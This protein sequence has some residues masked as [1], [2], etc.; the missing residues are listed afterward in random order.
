MN[1]NANTASVLAAEFEG[2]IEA[3]QLIESSHQQLHAEVARLRQELEDRNRALE[4]S[5]GQLESTRQLLMRILETLPC[6]VI[7]LNPTG[8]SVALANEEAR[9][10]LGLSALSGE[11][12]PE[13]LA[14]ILS[15]IDWKA[16]ASHSDEI[17]IQAEDS[18]RWLAIKAKRVQLREP[19]GDP[20]RI[21]I[22]EDVS[23]QKEFEREREQVRNSLALAE[24]S[25]VLA[26]EIRNPLGAMELFISLLRS[27]ALSS[28]AL[29][30]ID[31]LTAGV[32]SLSATVNNVLHFYATGCYRNSKTELWP[33]VYGI[34]SFLQPLFKESSIDLNVHNYADGVEV[35]CDPDA[36]RQVIVNLCSNAL[37]HSPEGS[38]VEVFLGTTAGTVFVDVK[39]EGAGIAPEH[40]AHIFDAGYSGSCR[41]AGLGLAVCKR[42]AQVHGGAVTVVSTNKSGTTMRLELPCL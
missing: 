7:L 42:I 2:F 25:S 24:M 17:C 11:T 20:I 40:L 10:L 1:V 34:V 13:A 29:T 23:A 26:H 6:G 8:I 19:N 41:H 36:I 31:H 15:R 21:I 14:S 3:A 27:Q 28:D 37:R 22:A 30:W 5:L 38:S 12:L 16:G 33:I 35:E 32:Q 9:R 18:S 39:D 4:K